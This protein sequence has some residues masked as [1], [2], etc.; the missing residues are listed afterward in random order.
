LAIAPQADS[1]LHDNQ[2][3][4]QI[5]KTSDGTAGQNHTF[6]ATSPVDGSGKLLYLGY[7]GADSEPKYEI[8]SSDPKSPAGQSDTNRATNN[9]K[10]SADSNKG[11]NFNTKI[12]KFFNKELKRQK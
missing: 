6:A 7:H 12:L 11:E 5:V 10:D 9:D 1:Q 8:S 2:Q 3:Q 4:Q